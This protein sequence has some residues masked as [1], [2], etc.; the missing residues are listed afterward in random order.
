MLDTTQIIVNLLTIIGAMV[1]GFAFLYSKIKAFIEKN[2]EAL[3]KPVTDS[4]ADLNGRIDKVDN[5]LN[6]RMDKLDD[7]INKRMDKVDMESCKNYLVR[8]LSDLEKGEELSEAA[9][10]RYAEQY[11]HYIGQGENSYIK[12][13]TEKFRAE[14]KL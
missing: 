8:C 1:T 2:I 6:S 7:E 10:I 13:E 3:V 4:I 11:D 14:G 5:T 12:S 9:K